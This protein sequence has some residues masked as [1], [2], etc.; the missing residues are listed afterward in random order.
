MSKTS[1]VK[2]HHGTEL[3]DP[4]RQ[5]QPSTKHPFDLFAGVHLA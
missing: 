1:H 3:L 5:Q 2:N 4:D